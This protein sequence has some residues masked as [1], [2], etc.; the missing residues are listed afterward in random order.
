M[1]I[2]VDKKII[3]FQTF[4]IEIIERNQK[5]NFQGNKRTLI[6]KLDKAIC[7]QKD[8]LHRIA[9]QQKEKYILYHQMQFGEFLLKLKNDG[10]KDYLL[11]LNKYGDNIFC[12]F[13]ITNHHK[14]KGI[15][16]YI[17]EDKIVYIGRSKK[18]FNERFKGYGK[19]TPYKSLING[20]STNCNINSKVNELKSIK[21]GFYLMN[22]Y[23]DIEIE[24]LEKKIINYIKGGQNL[25]NVKQY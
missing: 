1:R 21:V 17:I 3:E 16:C 10:N 4:E 6:Y 9:N 13:K 14:D 7:N 25:W 23:S 15:Y 5:N 11:Y 22:N 18:T 24:E 2:I 19:I 12:N 8:R 20:Q